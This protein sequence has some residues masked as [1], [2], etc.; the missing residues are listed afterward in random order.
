MNLQI[1]HIRPASESGPRGTAAGDVHERDDFSNLILLC[2]PHH[3]EVDE[4]PDVYTVEEL[5]AWKQACERGR[6]AA[7]SNIAAFSTEDGLRQAI[8]DA[9]AAR[10]E[11]LESTLARLENN[12]H[13][14]A[15]LLR[16][17]RDQLAVARETGHLVDPDS[18]SLAHQAAA[19]LQ[20]LPDS[21]ETALAAAQSLQN[22]EG[23]AAA[24]NQAAARIE[25]AQQFM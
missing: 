4:Y 16:E 22:L 20:H 8:A 19:M 15:L 13:E 23:V 25:A 1:A 24:I 9:L 18:A 3:D 2:K 21:A 11:A 5:S 7:L 6:Q 10:D 14:A 17:M 12:D